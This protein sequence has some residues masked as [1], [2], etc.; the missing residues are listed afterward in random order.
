MMNRNQLTAVQTIQV[1]L[2]D[3]HPLIRAGIRTVLEGEADFEVIGEA[4]NGFEV[5]RLS[6]ALQPDV[7]L[8]D[9][10][11]PKFVPIE[12][13]YFLQEQ[14]PDTKLAILTAYDDDVYVRSLVG[15]GVDAYILKDEATKVVADVI[16]VLLHGGK[17]YSRGVV[18]TLASTPK[19]QQKIPN[20]TQRERQILELIVCGFSDKHI[21]CELNLAIQTVRNYTSRLYSKLDVQSRTQA[22]LWARKYHVIVK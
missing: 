22:I 14:C 1:L 17:W 16:R 19:V 2:A 10:K 12:T 11:M 15:V 6:Q 13:V 9:L 20:L 7:V 3:D 4:T 18:E 8:L 5:K 21:A